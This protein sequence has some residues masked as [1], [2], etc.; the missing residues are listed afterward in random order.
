MIPAVNVAYVEPHHALDHALLILIKSGYSAI[1]VLER[2]ERVRGTISKTLIL[3]SILGLEQIEVDKLRDRQVAEVMNADVPRLHAQDTMM[4]ALELSISRPFLCV[5]AEDGTFLGLVTRS[6][7][8][9]RVHAYC[10]WL[11]AQSVRTS[12]PQPDADAVQ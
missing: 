9:E 10:R 11:K 12:H 5:E 1:P 6:A 7:I 8:L 3:D 2:G 4:K